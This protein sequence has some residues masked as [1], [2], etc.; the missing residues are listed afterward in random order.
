[1]PAHI[2]EQPFFL[3]HLRKSKW[4]KYLL[5]RA[6]T[7]GLFSWTNIVQPSLATMALFINLK[8]LN[9]RPPIHFGL[10]A[11]LQGIW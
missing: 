3:L 1:M 6:C 8:L 10:Q 9:P 11:T 7:R 4:G 2:H 5:L